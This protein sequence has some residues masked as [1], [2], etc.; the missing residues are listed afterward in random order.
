M[1][2]ITKSS[3]HSLIKDVRGNVAILF[4]VA[5]I[6]V[7][8]GVGVAVDYGRALMVRERMQGALDAA[9]LAVGSWPGL[10]EAQMQAKAQ[11]Y[12][13]ANFVPTNSA[14]AGSFGT[15]SPLHLSTSGNSI[16][17]SASAS[18]PTT[19]MRV[20]NIDHVDVAASTTVVV[21]MG[22]AEVALALDN[23]GSMAGSKIDS[24]KTAASDLVDTL[25]DAAQNSSEADPIKIAIVPFAASVNV[26][27]QY[28]NASWMDTIGVGKYH[29]YEQK[30]YGNGG[31]LNSSGV[32]SVNVGTGINNFTLFDLAKD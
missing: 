10:S 3:R 2:R 27:T 4:G 1:S 8:V 32:C 9:T 19:F 11:E 21:G 23:S 18:V 20:A 13:N 30:C 31:T 15:V 12:F 7:L 17:V 6:P 5:L 22:T 25:Y 28:A 14:T 16:I 26:G 29:A 24:L